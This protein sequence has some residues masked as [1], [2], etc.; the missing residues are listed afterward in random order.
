MKYIYEYKKYT[1]LPKELRN[2]NLLYHATIFEYFEETLKKNILYGSGSYDYGISTSRNK[3]YNFGHDD[4]YGEKMHNRGD[5]QFI[6]D[7]DKIK[8]ICKI[9]AFDWEE[10]KS[11]DSI[12]G[13]YNDYHQSEDKILCKNNQLINF[14]KYII[15][16]HIANNN[17]INDVLNNENIE[18]DWYIFD[19]D[20]N[21]IKF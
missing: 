10:Y 21:L 8:N 12:T 11:T 3:H 5:I 17:Y 7:K 2:K 16:L 20:W 6:L 14:K 9:K 4:E 18:K 15:G 19:E 1:I 13:T